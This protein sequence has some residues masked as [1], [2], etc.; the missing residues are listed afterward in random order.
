MGLDQHAHAI[1]RKTI[2]KKDR[3]ED[4]RKYFDRLPGFK[5]PEL[6]AYW[7]KHPNLECWMAELWEQKGGRGEFN[8]EYVELTVTDLDAL[9]RAVRGNELPEIDDGLFGSN[10][11]EYYADHDL[12]FIRKAR[13]ALEDGNEVIY[14]SWW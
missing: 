2:F 12:E 3:S 9:E 8:C 7:R 10:A 1:E 11:D 5:K 6:L 4:Y 13:N 14:S